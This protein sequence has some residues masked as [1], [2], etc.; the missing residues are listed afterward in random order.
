[1][2]HYGD[3]RTFSGAKSPVKGYSKIFS[4]M[5]R[6]PFDGLLSSHKF[7]LPSIPPETNRSNQGQLTRMKLR[8]AKA[9]YSR[10]KVGILLLNYDIVLPNV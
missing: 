3:S 4:M 9:K 5:Y 8:G 10:V 6:L 2:W 7:T 1:M